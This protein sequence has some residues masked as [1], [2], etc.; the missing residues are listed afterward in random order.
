MDGLYPCEDDNDD[1]D[2]W[3]DVV[4]ECPL[5]AGAHEKFECTQ[6][7]VCAGTEWWLGCNFT[8]TGCLELMVKLYEVVNPVPTEVLFSRFEIVEQTMYIQ[9]LPGGLVADISDL[10]MG[11]RRQA[12]A[13]R[14]RA[15][16][17]HPRR[18]GTSRS[19]PRTPRGGRRTSCRW[20]R[21]TS[22]STSWSATCRRADGLRSIHRGLGR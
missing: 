1:G 3:P 5:V 14:L 16:A 7:K 15:R 21:A 11:G 19:G 18:S 8:G 22:Q 10:V 9:S 4:D 12:A 20:W 6:V 17:R 2:M 13:A